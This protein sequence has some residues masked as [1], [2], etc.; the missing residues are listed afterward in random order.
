MAVPIENVRCHY[1]CVGTTVP[2][3]DRPQNYLA[4][5]PSFV[6]E[7]HH[8]GEIESRFL[9]L[10]QVMPGLAYRPPNPC[11]HLVVLVVVMVMVALGLKIMARPA[12]LLLRPG[13]ARFARPGPFSV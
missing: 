12:P 5:W 1:N 9:G 7:M 2:R 11:T 10:V 4:R 8:L 3:R 13:L 6:D